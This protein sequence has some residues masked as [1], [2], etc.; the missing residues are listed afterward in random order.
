MIILDLGMDVILMLYTSLG[1]GTKEYKIQSKIEKLSKEYPDI[2][3][4]YRQNQRVFETDDKLGD[5]I[6]N[7]NFK[8]EI[9]KKKFV[10]LMQQRFL[11]AL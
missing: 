11:D 3:Q 7:L 1:F 5:L 10:S 8:S 2:L 6:L 4:C 9:N